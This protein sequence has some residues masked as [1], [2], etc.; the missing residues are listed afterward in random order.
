MVRLLAHCLLQ[1]P[2]ADVLCGAACLNGETAQGK[3]GLGR[4]IVLTGDVE[5]ADATRVTVAQTNAIPMDM[6]ET[7]SRLFP[8]QGMRH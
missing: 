6:L 2:A 4:P 8:A 5:P 1:A 7:V 3:S